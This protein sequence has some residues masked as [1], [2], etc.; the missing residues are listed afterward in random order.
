MA[1]QFVRVRLL[2]ITGVDLNLFEFDLD[3]TWAA[4]FMNADG[5]I[6]GRY[7]GRDASGPDSR[8][9]LAG[10]RY[11][12]EGALAAHRDA[13]QREE[14]IKPAPRTTA[15]LVIDN[16]PAAKAHLRG[17]IHCHQAK[18]ILRV[19]ANREG[20]W[21]PLTRWVYPLPENVGITLDMNRGD[22][23]KAVAAA[24]PAAQAGLRAGD[25]LVSLG[26]RSVRSFGDA[27]HALHMAPAK[28]AVKV[29]WLR[30]GA[31]HDGELKLADGWK[32]TNLT[33]RPSLMD[34]LPSLPLFGTDL[35]VQEK[36]ALGLPGARLAF[37][38]D[39]PVPPSAKKLGVQEGDVIVGI[40]E[41]RLEM[42]VEQ[43]LGYV[44]RNYL[45]GDRV[46]LNLVR[47]EKR[48]DVP[49]KLP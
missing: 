23:V 25:T 18:E 21:D 48:L 27:Q 44:R 47:G 4:F 41:L 29:A 38:Q 35:T 1:K 20:G 5:H 45:L 49:I 36:Q 6:Y 37:R 9:T 33:W 17:C 43:F 34:L 30:D 15:R 24:S 16:V 19:Q 22:H 7:G 8:N 32:K 31:R 10:L 14:N 12:L 28:G 26:Y 39:A 11:A 13:A 42:T 2:R 40:N 46:T 3:L